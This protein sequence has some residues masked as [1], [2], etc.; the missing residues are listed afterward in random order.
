MSCFRLEN[1]SY[2]YDKSPV[3]TGIYLNLCNR[4]SDEL[5]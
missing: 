1:V 5:F 4:R 2:R 3:L